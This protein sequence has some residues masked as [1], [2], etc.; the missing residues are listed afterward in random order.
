MKVL[1][2]IAFILIVSFNGYSQSISL[3]ELINLNNANEDDFDTFIIRKA[4]KYDS[5]EKLSIANRKSYV[6]YLE[7]VKNSYVTKFIFTNSSNE[8]VSFQTPSSSI[9]LNFKM[10]LKKL[11]FIFKKTETYENTT[12]MYYTKGNLELSLTSST[13][14][15][16]TSGVKT[17]YEISITKIK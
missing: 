13:D 14:E 17:F 9:Y 4:F 5:F 10:D 16:R 12:F 15:S 8:M 7:G 3:T 2:N 11:G 1:F 6:Y